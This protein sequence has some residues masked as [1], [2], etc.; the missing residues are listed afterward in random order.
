M[1][2]GGHKAHLKNKMIS[3]D[4]QSVST[5]DIEDEKYLWLLTNKRDR[6]NIF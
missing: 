3:E 2:Y 5:E 4:Y 1:Y 6:S